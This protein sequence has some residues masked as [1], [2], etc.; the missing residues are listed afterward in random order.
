MIRRSCLISFV[1][2]AA[3]AAPVAACPVCDTATGEQVRAGILDEDFA[4]NVL[5]MLLPFPILIGIAAAIHFGGG[6]GRRGKP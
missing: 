3:L 5:A 4:F 2:L 1:M 6:G